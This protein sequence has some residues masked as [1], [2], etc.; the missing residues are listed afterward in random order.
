MELT[1]KQL[2]NIKLEFEMV[3]RNYRKLM[4]ATYTFNILE[5]IKR[6]LFKKKKMKQTKLKKEEECSAQEIHDYVWYKRLRATIDHGHTCTVKTDPNG[7]QNEVKI[8]FQF[9]YNFLKNKIH[10]RI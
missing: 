5:I 2:V 6:Q 8:Y 9:F 1:K 3:L 7:T 4:V 10:P